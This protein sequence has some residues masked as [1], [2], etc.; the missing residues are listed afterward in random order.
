MQLFAKRSLDLKTVVQFLKYMV[1]GTVYFW[2]GYLVFAIC[3]SGL[4]W[5]WLP[6]KMLADV[7]GW[8]LNYLIQ[9]YWAFADKN[10][11]KNES[12][13]IEKYGL[14]SLFNLGLDYLI[15]AGLKMVGVSPYVGFF[16]SAGFFTVW[17]YF[18]YRFWVF[19]I[20]DKKKGAKNDRQRA[21][22]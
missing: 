13:T 1:G 5:D 10:L 12:R 18:I 7:V 9:R 6:S 17:N 4:H 20:K 19:M 21:T 16:I 8:T 15:I 3:Y 22:D 14:V 11:D 2:S